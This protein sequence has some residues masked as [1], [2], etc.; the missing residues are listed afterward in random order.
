MM[1]YNQV[2]PAHPGYALGNIITITNLLLPYY[3]KKSATL[4]EEL[5]RMV[6]EK[7]EEKEHADSAKQQKIINKYA[8]MILVVQKEI[9]DVEKKIIKL[10]EESEKNDGNPFAIE[11]SLPLDHRYVVIRSEHRSFYS[12]RMSHVTF[13]S[14]DKLYYTIKEFVSK[15][16]LQEASSSLLPLGVL[17]GM[18]KTIE[19][20]LVDQQTEV[21]LIGSFITLERV[22]KL[23]PMKFRDKA[24]VSQALLDKHSKYCVLSE[25][26]LG[27]VFLGLGKVISSNPK[28]EDTIEKLKNV[29]STLSYVCQGAI[30]RKNGIHDE[31]NLFGL[32][33][34]WKESLLNDPHSGYP[35]GFK[36]R[37]LKEILQEN[38]I[39][40]PELP[41]E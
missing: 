41:N 27:G 2:Y 6:T 25:A 21:T 13:K 11:E 15:L 7:N 9:D 12:E 30:P 40:V 24:T 4:H 16:F 1:S 22:K 33:S 29:F 5:E 20:I 38:N 14:K 10:K 32:Y 26:V 34:Q 18:A 8:L 37:Y 31:V 35:F 39:A 28:D 3:N 17:E 19:A 36:V 23:D